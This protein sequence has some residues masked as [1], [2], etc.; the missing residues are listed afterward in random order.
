MSK[1]KTYQYIL[2]ILMAIMLSACQTIDEAA[3]DHHNSQQ[4]WQSLA[5]SSSGYLS[6]QGLVINAVPKWQE[7]KLGRKFQ[8]V[9]FTFGETSNE[10]QIDLVSPTFTGKY[11]CQWYCEHLHEV[12]NN[13]TGYYTYLSRLYVANQ[14]ALLHFYSEI[15]ALQQQ[16]A[17]L[18]ITRPSLTLR[19]KKLVLLDVS[20]SSLP[21]I[22]A[23]LQ[24]NLLQ[25]QFLLSAGGADINDTSSEQKDYGDPGLAVG[26]SACS[27]SDNFFG[28]VIEFNSS[29]AILAIHGQLKHYENGKA[30]DMPSGSLKRATKTIYYLPMDKLVTFSL[31]DVFACQAHENGD[32]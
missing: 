12:N 24:K 9:D 26:H 11:I 13:G 15:I 16:V 30:S 23:V 19:I 31:I 7:T 5:A 14:S 10:Y 4:A 25:E 21:E 8:L 29:Q 22:L 2:A 27:I 32:D 18:G 28:T 17:E 20:M 1:Q 3:N 6:Q